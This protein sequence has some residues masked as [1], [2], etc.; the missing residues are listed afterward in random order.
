MTGVSE[1]SDE[2]VSNLD[3]EVSDPDGGDEEVSDPAAAQSLA[4][5]HT[6]RNPA[7]AGVS[8]MH[9]GPKRRKS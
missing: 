8:L 3:E 2:V 4:Y 6:S 9:G 1:L 5:R 7:A